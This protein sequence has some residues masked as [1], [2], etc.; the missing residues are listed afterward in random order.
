MRSGEA[1]Q[2]E[3]AGA[4]LAV[5]P[6]TESELAKYQSQMQTAALAVQKAQADA[7]KATTELQMKNAEAQT[8][9]AKGVI[10]LD[11]E[12]KRAAI[13]QANLDAARARLELIRATGGGKLKE[14]PIKVKTQLDALD[15]AQQMLDS[16]EKNPPSWHFGT[17][18]Q[19]IRDLQSK[20]KLAGLSSLASVIPPN[21]P[22]FSKTDVKGML[23][24]LKE[25]FQSFSDTYRQAVKENYPKYKADSTPEAKAGGGSVDS[26][27]G[28]DEE[29]DADI[30]INPEDME[31]P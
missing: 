19:E 10:S 29:V 26:A 28:D 9:K 14:P 24:T 7:Q 4:G 18:P 21:A 15:Q 25:G 20:L 11:I 22:V 12:T 27:G 30:V 8:A 2:A 17:P 13:A 16:M 5:T 6:K 3:L 23:A 31:K 1:R